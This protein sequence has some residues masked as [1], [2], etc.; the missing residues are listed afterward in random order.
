MNSLVSVL[1]RVE[2]AK[3]WSFDVSGRAVRSE[4]F[5]ASRGVGVPGGRGGGGR[6]PSA[7]RPQ[8]LAAR[9]EGAPGGGAPRGQP[10]AQVRRYTINYFYTKTLHRDCYYVDFRI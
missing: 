8:P 9:G 5:G 2:N 6:G 1:V 10:G 4:R 3:S 7:A